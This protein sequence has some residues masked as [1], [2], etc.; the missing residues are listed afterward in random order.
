MEHTIQNVIGATFTQHTKE[1]KKCRK[2]EQE[3]IIDGGSHS[4]PDS[5][6]TIHSELIFDL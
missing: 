3:V 2:R 6:Y 4:L 1:R 5:V